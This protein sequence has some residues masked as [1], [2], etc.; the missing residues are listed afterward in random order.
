LIVTKRNKR[1]YVCEA[2]SHALGQV[3]ISNLNR[4]LAGHAGAKSEVVYTIQC[5]QVASR[6]RLR[7][8][9]KGCGAKDPCSACQ[10]YVVLAALLRCES[11]PGND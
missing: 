9:A 2:P 4:I 1:L 6:K 3:P 10:R 5:T 7:A 11:L 8:T